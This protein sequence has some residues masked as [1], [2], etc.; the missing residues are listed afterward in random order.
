[1]D[2]E[3][4]ATA[5]SAAQEVILALGSE[6][7]LAK[8]WSRRCE[9]LGY[10]VAASDAL[11]W[12]RDLIADLADAP[13]T[14]SAPHDEGGARTLLWSPVQLG[15]LRDAI[16][17]RLFAHLPPDEVA[18]AIVL[19]DTATDRLVGAA[20][21]E[22]LAELEKDAR[23]DPL[24]DA[25]NR[26]ALDEDLGREL[27]RASRHDRQVTVLVVDLD[28]LKAINDTHGHEAGDEA[29][30]R[31]V[32]SFRDQ[33]RISD[34]I[35]RI[36]GDEFVVVLLDTSDIAVEALVAR[37]AL[38]APAFSVGAATAPR[39][40][41]TARELIDAA[42][43]HMFENRRTL[44]Q[45]RQVGPASPINIQEVTAA[46]TIELDGLRAVYEGT[47]FS[48][49]VTLTDGHARATGSSDGSTLP[50]ATH[51]AV[52]DATMNALGQLLPNVDGYYVHDAE[53]TAAHGIDI[54]TVTVTILTTSRTDTLVG[55]AA[56]PRSQHEGIVHA[57][58][59]ATRDRAP[60]TPLG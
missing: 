16:K 33:L 44:S 24:T 1:M 49:E 60:L 8:D 46:P 11:K 29:L 41:K 47:R 37:T 38:T 54:A 51:R 4:Q 39:D 9:T 36:G 6:T 26:R 12:L 43:R 23:H 42:D 21:T 52:A 30:R 19:V 17:D 58:L 20:M 40:G 15:C 57:V 25:G 10:P 18:D 32:H 27:A 7:A 31:L 35:Y 2:H 5:P 3:G 50:R 59:S 55:S 13:N 14:V 22:R 28:G 53:L 48:A 34:G 45:S 56:C